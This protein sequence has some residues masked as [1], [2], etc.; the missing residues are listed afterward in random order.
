MT[1]F[2]WSL[3]GADAGEK[4]SHIITRKEA[5][6]RSGQGQFWW[7]LGTPL[8]DA[9]ESAATL[10]GGTLPALFSAL[11]DK[12]PD[13][14]EDPN[15]KIRVWNGWRSIRT[16]AHGNIPDHVL[17]TSGYDANKPDKPH[18]ALVCRSDVQLVLGNH[19]FFDPSQCRTV[20]NG[21][22]PGPSQR[23]ALLTRQ[24]PH[25]RGPYNIA[26]DASLVG[27]WYVRL[28]HGRV[29]TRAE[30]ARIRQ[31]KDGDDWLGLV[32]SLRDKT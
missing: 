12:E 7:G 9:V 1:P 23:A 5:E 3:M 22:A 16:G 14:K 20:K 17:I 29:L 21:K 8:G 31:Y 28:T 32:K 30:L 18:Y 2:V 15:Q 10:N 13:Q 26:F 25:S 11:E 6:R 27:P 24:G 19:G 4:L